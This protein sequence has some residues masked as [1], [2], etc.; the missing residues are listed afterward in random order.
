[1]VLNG[2]NR[3]LD[4]TDFFHVLGLGTSC[5]PTISHSRILTL[6]STVQ[7]D[8]SLSYNYSI[9]VKIVP[10]IRQVLIEVATRNTYSIINNIKDPKK[11]FSG[12]YNI[13]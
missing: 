12:I 6:R 8:I 2:V 13:S 3:N 1:M 10:Q 9:T 7:N 11:E 5:K 4:K